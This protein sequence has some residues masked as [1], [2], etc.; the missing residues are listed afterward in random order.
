MDEAERQKLS[1]RDK[2]LLAALEM[3]EE[4]PAAALS[5]RAVAARAGISTGSLRH[6]FPTQRELQDEVLTRIYDRAVP[7]DRIADTSVPARD[8]LAGSLGQVLTEIGVG[9]RARE[10]TRRAVEEFVVPEPTE[11][12]SATYSAIEQQVRS[13]VEYWL[14][15]LTN[16][17][18]LPE[19][20]NTRRARFLLTVLNGLG[21]ER[22]LPAGESVLASET[23]TLYMAVDCVLN[24]GRT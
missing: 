23:D 6:H 5:V 16:E 9:A 8:R 3:F 12:I 7:G 13:R 21:L 20:D 4:N 17:G 18:A 1:S 10:A 15:V 11:Q 14:T 2:A 19:G 22:A 24:P